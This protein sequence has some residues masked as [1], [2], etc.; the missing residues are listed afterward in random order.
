MFQTKLVKIKSSKNISQLTKLLVHFIYLYIS[1]MI[2]FFKYYVFVFHALLL[3]L[4]CTVKI[5][6]PPFPET[7]QLPQNN[8]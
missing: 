7:V 2:P 6:I 5:A 3:L 8:V 4:C 1:R